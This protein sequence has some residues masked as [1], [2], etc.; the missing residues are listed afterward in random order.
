MDNF[1]TGV[2]ALLLF[3]TAC[4]SPTATIQTGALPE[5]QARAYLIFSDELDR[6]RNIW[7][8]PVAV[9]LAANSLSDLP[10]GGPVH[11]VSP[12][13]LDRLRTDNDAAAVKLAIDSS[14]DCIKSAGTADNVL[15]LAGQ[16]F[17][18]RW[19]GNGNCRQFEG[20]LYAPPTNR[21]VTYDF[22]IRNGKVALVGGEVCH[23][24][25]YRA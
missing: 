3:L 1:R 18:E 12:D 13:V 8:K 9:C 14:P 4:A 21:L 22:E 24:G 17:G 23:L 2:A 20:V 16:D 6:V 19:M 10:G 5:E 25:W 15:V 7:K 11:V